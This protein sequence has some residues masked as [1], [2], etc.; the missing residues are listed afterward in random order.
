[1]KRTFALL[2]AFL[3]ACAP[4][5]TAPSASSPQ[6][7]AAS[8]P[9]ATST[10]SL[11]PPSTS[12]PAATSP[13]G[14]ARP[15]SAEQLADALAD[16]LGRSDY[17]KLETLVTPTRWFGGFYQGGGTAGMTPR[18]TIDWLRMRTRSGTIE[19][20]VTPRPVLSPAP[21]QPPGDAYVRS[22]WRN[23]AEFPTQNAE[24]TMRAES[25]IWYWSGALFNAPTR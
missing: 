22:L 15:T 13:G 1:M 17:A 14:V 10:P 11:T 24:L 20:A 4:A 9:T 3:S 7:T 23:F 8:I 19:A 5:P 12:A 2:L 18:E 25:G 21:N 6:S 16:A